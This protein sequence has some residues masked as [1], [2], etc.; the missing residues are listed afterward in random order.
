MTEGVCPHCGRPYDAQAGAIQVTD[1]AHQPS[2]PAHAQLMVYAQD[3]A[4]AYAR[5]KLMAPYLPGDLRDRIAWGDNRIVAERRYVTVMFADLVGF[6]RLASLLDAEGLFSLMNTCFQRLVTHILRYEGV[7]DK[8]MGDGLMA[9]FGAPVAHEDD[10][11]RAVRA[12]LDMQKEIGVFSSEMQ[13]RLGVPLQLHIGINS[14]EVIAG[15]I[16]VA[17]R[18]SYTVTGETV[19][20]AFRLQQLAEPGRIFV[21]ETIYRQTEH[22]F[23]YQ[24]LGEFQVKG[25]QD[26]VPVFGVREEREPS[27]FGSPVSGI[28]LPWIGRERELQHLDHL[29]ERLMQ[30]AGG[31]V[32]VSGEAGLG[33]TRLAQEWLACLPY[34]DVSVWWA[35]AQLFRQRISYSLWRDLLRQGLHLQ[36]GGVSA[37]GLAARRA[38]LAQVG[39]GAPFLLALIHSQTSESGPARLSPDL[40]RSHTLRAVRD[41]LVAQASRSPL[42]LI[43]DNWQWA[44]DLSRTLLLSLLSLSDEHPILFCILTRPGNASSEHPLRDIQARMGGSCQCLELAPLWQAKSW[45]LLAPILDVEDLAPDVRSIILN[46]TQGNPL[47]LKEL[48]RLMKSERM[49]DLVAAASG[50][51]LRWRVVRPERLASLGVP[52]TLSGLAQANLD[53]LPPE[54]Q[55]ILSYA[56]IIGPTFSLGL[57]QAV[58]AREREINALSARL[59]ELVTRG[60]LQSVAA[61]GRTFAFRDTIVQETIYNSL[62]SQRRR[63]IHRLVADELEILPE[64]DTNH[65]FELLTHHFVQAGVPAKA[66]PYLIRAGQRAQNRSAYRVAIEHYSSALAVLDDAPRYEDQ[67]LGLEVALAD[68]HSQLGQYDEAV[69]HYQNALSLSTHTEQQ[70]NLYRLIGSTLAAKGDWQEAWRYMQQALECLAEGQTAV[71]AAIRGEVYAA[72]A[73]VQWRLGDH[74]QAELW[75]HEGMVILEGSDAA[76]S[77]ALCYETLCAVYATFGQE[78]LADQYALQAAN[79]LQDR[80]AHYM[81]R[82]AYLLD[83][84]VQPMGL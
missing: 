14:G 74:Q 40:V 57:L 43:V 30:G 81:P 5:Q 33:K 2:T 26:P 84:E 4:R 77:L 73:L 38:L 17:E 68:A 19:N 10:P 49:V 16:G 56:S 27:T 36:P 53:R 52:P 83:W 8:F 80:S 67:R 59:D 13:P 61:D 79:L 60:V 31:V 29:A 62:L 54:L 20:L 47:Y 42:I 51:E 41:L 55:E 37:A 75:A 44:D 72:C 18:L 71:N 21:G 66:V 69:R 50:G 32:T 82:T 63:A 78:S 45:D 48:L 1:G 22:L 15:S 39:Q 12:A 23:D 7:I 28:A 70:T 25:F 24:S 35:T 64:S 76:D 3:L 11:E 46:R 65:S 58:V 34:E 9:L 6:T